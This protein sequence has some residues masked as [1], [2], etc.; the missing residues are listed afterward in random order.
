MHPHGRFSA[1][2]GTHDSGWH[3]GTVLVMHWMHW[4]WNCTAVSA[5]TVACSCALQ[6]HCHDPDDC[7]SGLGI[8]VHPL[9]TLAQHAST[10]TLGC[11]L[12]AA[13]PLTGMDRVDRRSLSRWGCIR[14]D[15]ETMSIGTKYST[16]GSVT[17]MPSARLCQEDVVLGTNALDAVGG[18]EDVP[19]SHRLRSDHRQQCFLSPLVMICTDAVYC[20]RC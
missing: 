17:G 8:S 11:V 16:R 7:P 20:A 2:T 3:L 10:V 18:S 1:V 6:G 12:K 19:R 4:G 9:H 13:C 14:G 5:P 15:N